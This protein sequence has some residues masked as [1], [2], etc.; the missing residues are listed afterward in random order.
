MLLCREPV[1]NKKNDGV[2]YDSCD[3]C[4]SCRLFE[5]GGHPDFNLVYKELREH[6][7]DGK[8]TKPPLDLQIDVIREFLIEKVNSRPV[9]SNRSVYVVCESE[10]L[11]SQA[12]NALLK[13]LEE[14]PAY[15]CIILLCTRLDKLLRTIL[16]RCQILRFGAI[17]ESRIVQE[18]RGLG[19]EEEE[20]LY[21]ARFV[22]GSIGEAIDWASVEGE[23][24]RCYAIKRELVERLVGHELADSVEFAEFLVGWSRKICESWWGRDKSVSKKDIARRAQKGL[25]RMVGLAFSDV[26]KLDAGCSEGL[27]NEDQ[28]REMKKLAGLLDV[29]EATRRVSKTYESMQWVDRNVN[30]KLIFEELLLNFAGSGIL[31]G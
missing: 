9:M 22:E 7:R 1:S 30:E 29:D 17:D 8:G 20:A 5:A 26:M 13:V 31:R 3:R 28:R 12:Q 25:L 15:C 18:L 23:W 10:K 6:T 24:G 14:P 11:S 2:F 27:V 21:W 19:V 16:S 4:E